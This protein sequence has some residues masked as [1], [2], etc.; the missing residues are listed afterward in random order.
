MPELCQ[1]KRFFL[2]CIHQVSLSLSLPLFRSFY[3]ILSLSFSL[4]L[5]FLLSIFLSLSVYLSDFLSLFP[6]YAA[7]HTD[8][9]R[10]RERERG[11]EERRLWFGQGNEE[12]DIKKS[13][14]APH[15]SSAHLSLFSLLSPS[16]SL[17]LSHLLAFL[18]L[19]TCHEK[20]HKS[21]G[22]TRRRRKGGGDTTHSVSRGALCKPPACQA[23]TGLSAWERKGEGGGGG[24]G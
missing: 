7:V 6:A 4:C 1:L 21:R 5:S 14:S 20:R 16:R 2:C 22:T 18:T 9:E 13:T 12:P 24:G 23:T 15:L 19:H 10:E 11:R 8:R 3:V 17:S